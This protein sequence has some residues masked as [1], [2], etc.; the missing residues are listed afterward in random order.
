[1]STF[2]KTAALATAAALPLLGALAVTAAEL[3]PAERVLP[4]GPVKP[5]AVTAVKGT[6]VI[7]GTFDDAVWAQA[8]KVEFK[9]IK[10]LHF[11]DDSGNTSGTI[12]AAYDAERIYLLLTYEDPT[13][14][15]RRSPF[16]KGAD[17]T[18]TKVKDPDDR[19]G[20]NNLAYEDKFALLWNINDS[21]L[22]FNEKL[23]CTS[24]CHGGEKGKPYGNKY[25][26]EEGEKGDIWHMK[27]VRTGPIGQVDDQW[28][29]HTRYDAEKAK[30]AG[31]KSDKKDGGGYDDVKLVNGKPE[32]MNKDGKAAN[33]GGTYWIKA[34]DKV[35]FDDAKFV[36]GDEVSSIIIAPFTGDRGEI[37]VAVVWKDGKY[38]AE[39][40][41]KL[42]TGS[43][44]DV[45]FEDLGK[46]Y[47]FGIG[48]FDNAQVR[49]AYVPEPFNLTFKK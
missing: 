46:L 26:E 21:I 12:Q 3:P 22:G 19:G 20:D 18:W 29:D 37:S 30:D 17:G 27:G 24:S 9:A 4:K 31:R 32:F 13:N 40:S 16:V 7:D 2:L 44:T 47:G 34:E 14:S 23:G 33:K 5:I 42:K 6:P 39:M 25:L 41:R 38:F 49:H 28:L 45:Q 11:K 10:G 36:A 35:P 43:P 15:V 48:L 1:M 8:P